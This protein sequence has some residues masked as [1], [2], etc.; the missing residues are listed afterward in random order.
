MPTLD[1]LL[2]EFGHMLRLLRQF[3]ESESKLVHVDHGCAFDHQLYKIS[4]EQQIHQHL[5]VIFVCG[6]VAN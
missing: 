5:F 3:F 4:G 2:E 1:K 6:Q